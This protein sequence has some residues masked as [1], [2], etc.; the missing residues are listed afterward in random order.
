MALFKSSEASLNNIYTLDGKVPLG[1]SIPF[2]LQHVLAMFVANIAPIMIV[3]GVCKL[4]PQDTASLIQT[5]MIVAGVGT[6]IQLFAVWKI[7]AR[8]PIVMGVSFT[9]VSIFC[10]VGTKWGF[11]AVLGAAIVGGI[12]E[13]LLGFFAKY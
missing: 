11:G 13:G 4:T 8:L 2:G 1:K 3:A 7:G 6:L 12:V 5:A 10:F 9:F